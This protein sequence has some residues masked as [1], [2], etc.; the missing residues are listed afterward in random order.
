MRMKI[1]NCIFHAWCG[2]LI[3]KDGKPIDLVKMLV[4]GERK[5]V[6][7]SENLRLRSEQMVHIQ[8]LLQIA[9]GSQERM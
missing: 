9:T 4:W 3:L 1:L 6:F 7:T 5:F 8:N 2:T